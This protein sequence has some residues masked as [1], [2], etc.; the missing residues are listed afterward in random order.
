[1]QPFRSII[2]TLLCLGVLAACGD[3]PQNAASNG[4]GG[5]AKV[6]TQRVELQPL[7][8][9]IEA[10]GTARAN[11]SIDI[12]SRVSSVVTRI[13][14]EEGQMVSEGALLIELENSEIV[15]GL[16]LAEASLAESQSL[17]D[18]SKS[19]ES[20]QA[21]SAS[22]LD[23]LLAQVKVNQARVEAARARLQNTQI[24]APFSGRVGLRH[25][26]P[27]SFVDS[28]TII[29]TLDDINKMKLDFSVPETFLM[30]VSEGMGILAE[31]IVFPDRIFEGTITSIDTRLDPVSR[32][33][34]VRAL[35]PNPDAALKP[36]MFLTVDLQR[37]RGDVLL[38]PEQS[39]VPEGTRQFVYV[40]NDGVAEKR[41]VTLGR[42]LPGF[43]VI[44][45]GLSP[46]TAVVTEGTHKVRDGSP[47]EIFDPGAAVSDTPPL[48]E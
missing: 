26:S 28:S 44:K 8:D 22:N 3:E 11:E 42:R 35:I 39:I 21:I 45:D 10:L 34:Q 16:V 15:A 37:D 25:V 14:F 6:V 32:S 9:E 36:G 12:Q 20:T 4:G 48:Q 38:A 23:E 24:R 7:V 27:G 13:A 2:T 19:L 41:A 31:S 30:V 5:P 43:V 46:G 29:S 18:R 1:M 47:V 33:V 40:V 17:Y